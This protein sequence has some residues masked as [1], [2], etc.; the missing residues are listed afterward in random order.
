MRL[1]SPRQ[2][3]ILRHMKRYRHIL[4]TITMTML[5]ALLGPSAGSG[6]AQAQSQSHAGLVVQ[7]PGGTTQTFCVPFAGESIS[8]LDLL[9]KSGLEVKAEVYGGLGAEI[10]QI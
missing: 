7:F 6:M 2:G 4:I 1:Y 3:S 9:L 5:L 10:C 8:G